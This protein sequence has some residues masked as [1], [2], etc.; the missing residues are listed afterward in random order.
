MHNKIVSEHIVTNASRVRE[1][2]SISIRWLGK[3]P[4]RTVRQKISD[5]GKMMGVFHLASI[6]TTENRLLKVLLIRLDSILYE[7]EQLAKQNNFSAPDSTQNFILKIHKWLRSEDAD[8]IGQWN[9][10]IPN[11]TFLNDKNY[12]KIWN[13]WCELNKA[14]DCLQNDISHLEELEATYYFWN[15]LSSL[16]MDSN[17]FLLQAPVFLEENPLDIVPYTE[18]IEGC[19]FQNGKLEQVAFELEKKERKLVRI[20]G[21]IKT[22]EK[23][24]DLSY[25]HNK[26]KIAPRQYNSSCCAFDFTN[27]QP[28]FAT[29]KN[30]NGILDVKLIYQTW[31]DKENQNKTLEVDCSKSK[32]ISTKMPLNTVTIHDFFK[33]NYEIHENTNPYLAAKSFSNTIKLQLNC[34]KYYYL[35]P[36]EIDDFSQMQTALRHQLNLKFSNINP[37]PRSIA[38]IFQI[39]QKEGKNILNRKFYIVDKYDTCWIITK[40]L[41]KMN[42]TL[43]EKYPDSDGIVF[44]HFPSAVFYDEN[45]SEDYLLTLK[46]KKLLADNFFINDNE[47]MK[48]NYSMNLSSLNQKFEEFRRNHDSDYDYVTITPDENITFGALFYDE[49]QAKTPDIMLWREHLPPLG[50]ETDGQKLILVDEN[51]AGISPKKG[52]EKEIEVSAFFEMPKGKDFYEFSLFKGENKTKSYAYLKDDSFPLSENVK[53]KLHLTYTYGKEQPYSLRF[54]PI[55]SQEKSPF[56]YVQVKWESVSHRDY[57]KLPY[58]NFCKEYTWDDMKHFEGRKN[59]RG[60]S[61]DFINEWLPAEFDKIINFGT[62]YEIAKIEQTN[63]NQKGRSTFLILKNPISGEL[64]ETEIFS[65]REITENDKI[66]CSKTDVNTKNP[67]LQSEMKILEIKTIFKNTKHSDKQKN[68]FVTEVFLDYE[69]GAYC[70]LISKTSDIRIGDHVVCC[71]QST[72]RG[73]NAFNAVLKS[74]YG[75]GHSYA[76]KKI[77]ESTIEKHNKY[78]TS[79]FLESENYFEGKVPYAK[80]LSN[81]QLQVGDKIYCSDIVIEKKFSL[82]DEA[83]NQFYKSLRMPVITVWGNGR[84]IEDNDV[85]TSLRTLFYKARSAAFKLALEPSAKQKLKDEML[86]FLC[87]IHKDTLQEVKE[88]LVPLMLRDDYLPNYTRHLSY[89][90]GDCSSEWQMNIINKVIGNLSQEPLRASSLKILATSLWRVK[91]CVYKL[92]LSDIKSIIDSIQIESKRILKKIDEIKNDRIL[93]TCCLEILLALFRRRETDDTQILETLSSKYDENLSLC[94]KN[95]TNISKLGVLKVKQRFTFSSNL[96][97]QEAV[98]KYASGNLG[99]NEIKILSVEDEEE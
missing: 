21:K 98:E 65:N 38:K 16:S 91:N 7:K 51:T 8:F 97:L 20:Q 10:S 52:E 89:I 19:V 41:P 62:F 3:K 54:V 32:M 88:Q 95:L 15:K 63:I 81:R 39:Y 26:K 76:I 87:A 60:N 74:E 17:Y 84:S 28:Y 53:C 13:A 66:I 46:D 78:F 85:P 47:P 27:I 5:N 99:E 64:F 67:C 61:S 86:F 44:E 93:Y 1:T 31:K 75:E 4:G 22:P 83:D 49:F 37:L 36:D 24:P 30:E 35:L 96:T 57:R 29:N 45:I 2:D 6:D 23:I 33:T 43:L 58:P 55:Y 72:N 59:K 69:S 68:T 77:I 79:V 11:N 12:R 25:V 50:L 94:I 40:I 18:K 90:I 73:Y 82:L 9:N 42:K 56:Q 14:N 70:F 34:E 71:I 80:I 48:I 92:S